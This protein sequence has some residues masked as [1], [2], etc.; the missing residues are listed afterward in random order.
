MSAGSQALTSPL[1]D[2]S[3]RDVCGS[4]P[5]Q[6]VGV[7]DPD[8]GAAHLDAAGVGRDEHVVLSGPVEVDALDH[9]E[10]GRRLRCA[11][12][13]EVA[14]GAKALNRLQLYRLG[15]CTRAG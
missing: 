6:G 14:V 5:S 2:R 7:G 3:C 4:Q 11:D 15:R 1:H 9:R 8:G 10:G 12:L 13:A